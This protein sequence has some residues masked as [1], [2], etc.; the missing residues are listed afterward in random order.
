LTPDFALNSELQAAKCL[1]SLPCIVFARNL[2]GDRSVV[3]LSDGCFLLTEYLPD[4]LCSQHASKASFNQIIYP[5]DWIE[6]LSCIE[7]AALKSQSYGAEYRIQTKSGVQKWFLEQGTII[8]ANAIQPQ[9][10]EGV[11]VDISVQ[12]QAQSQLQRDAFFDPLTGLPNRSLFIDRLS[13]AVR[14]IQRTADDPFAVL[15]LDLDRFKVINDSL[16]HRAGDQLLIQVAQRLQSC[17]RP[18]DTVARLGGDEF[19]MLIDNVRDIQDVIQLC[20]RVLNEMTVPFQMEGQEIFTTMSIGIAPSSSGYTYPE[21]LIRDADIA[22][23]QAKAL[24]KARYAMFQPGMH[25][26]A[27]ARLQLENDLRRAI[28]RQEFC[29]LYQPIIAMETGLLAGFE[30]F[31]Y[32]HHP[33][34]G[35]LGP[36][37]FLS[38]AED[39]GLMVTLGQ[40]VLATACTQ[41]SLWH[42]QFPL[43]RSVF[44]SVNLSSFEISHPELIDYLQTTLLETKLNPRCLKLEITESMLM[45]N[46]EAVLAQLQHIKALGVQLCLDDFGTGYSSLSYLDQFPIDFLKI[47]RSFI[48]RVDS[49]EN[50]EIVRTILS[51]A[52][53]LGLKVVAEG[54]ETTA[55]LAQLRAL[56]CEFGQGYS[57]SRPLDALQTMYFIQEQFSDEPLTSITIALPRLFIHSQSGRYQLLLIGR[58]SWSLGRSQDC[59]IFLADRMVSREHAVI[60]QLTQSDEFYFVDLGSRNGSFINHQRVKAPTLLHNGDRIR[61]G[62]SEL[63]FWATSGS[64]PSIIGSRP[65]TILMYQSSKLQG[66]IWREVLMTQAISIIWQATDGELLQTL[67]QIEASGEALPDLLLLDVES[68]QPNL[69]AFFEWLR[70]RYETFPIILTYDASSPLDPQLRLQ[71]TQLGLGALLPGFLLSG[72]DLTTNA[73]DVAQKV[74]QVLQTL[75]LTSDT[76]RILNAS[77]AALQAIIR[78]ETLF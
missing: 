31:I 57:F 66:Q 42:Q 19:T 53:T 6:L 65:K 9:R 63:E 61:V 15:F 72:P 76:H 13:Q 60:L 29:L 18:G 48:Q 7:L 44:V 71:V 69:A 35:L 75:R 39:M 34:R 26:H 49:T 43:S 23:Y 67:H 28:Q 52:H 58:T 54:L 25:I 3:S 10:I 73:T 8:A 55:Q 36:G 32:W 21:D 14:R 51:L 47:D 56:R 30:T 74:N 11:I 33:N 1:Q 22:L 17:I 2:D 27:V 68:L 50:L 16:G 64:E 38:V 5:E 37:E 20:E 45:N 59:T 40:W 12:K 70:L 41:V 46:S 62:K 78:N 4:E 77:T 24:G